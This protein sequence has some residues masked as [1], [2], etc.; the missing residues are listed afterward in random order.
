M[1]FGR[2]GAF[3]IFIVGFMAFQVSAYADDD[4]WVGARSDNTYQN[5]WQSTVSGHDNICGGFYSKMGTYTNVVQ[6]GWFGL[7]YGTEFLEGSDDS[8]YGV[9]NHDFFMVCTHGGAWSNPDR[10]VQSM[11]YQGYNIYSTDMRLGDDGRGLSLFASFSCDIMTPNS[12]TSTNMWNR[13]QSVFKG[14]LR[15]ASGFMTSAY[16]GASMGYGTRYAEEMH[17]SGRTLAQ[18]W[19]YV[20]DDYQYQTPTSMVTQYTCSNCNDYL[21]ACGWRMNAMTSSNYKNYPKL[22][23]SSVSTFCYYYVAP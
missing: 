11:Y 23:D 17:V 21:Y 9:D 12:T 15:I 16:S 7:S 2:L 19:N 20:M 6:K 13:W 10:F 3:A 14:G 18:A 5:T 22:V 4:T 1:R 8:T